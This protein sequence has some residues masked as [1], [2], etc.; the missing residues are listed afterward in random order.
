MTAARHLFF[1]RHG[2]ADRAAYQGSDDHERPLVPEGMRRSRLTASVLDRLG[3][4]PDLIITS[5]LLRARQTAQIVADGLGLDDR[6]QVDDRLGLGFNLAALTAILSG[7]PGEARDIML[8]GHEPG[9][10]MVIGALTGGDVAMRKG[11]LARVDLDPGIP[12]RG[13]LVWLLQPRVFRGY[14]TPTM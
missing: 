14:T 11:A 5:P 8:V 13:Q 12:L 10:S 4:Q 7:V 1:L 3:L 9:Q 6:L 2:R